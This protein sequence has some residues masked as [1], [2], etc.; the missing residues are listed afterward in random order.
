MKDL[1]SACARLVLAAAF[2][3]CMVWPDLSA[4]TTLGTFHY[5]YDVSWGGFRIGVLRLSL[6]PW[7]GHTDCYRYATKTYPNSIV[8]L[9]YG[10]PSEVSLFCLDH[11][12]IQ[13]KRFVSTLPGRPA[14][15]YTLEFNWKRGV[16]TNNKG[17]TRKIPADAVDGLAIQQA[18]RLWMLRHPGVR[19]GEV[20]RFT[21]VDDKHL[22]KYKLQFE[23]KRVLKTPAG[24]FTTLLV[25]RIDTPRKEARFWLAPARKDMPV[26]SMVRNGDRP[27]IT[28]VLARTQ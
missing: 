20:A 15:S 16:V 21:M 19:P 13:S 2:L 23:G 3:L 1:A 25:R 22:T 14:Q 4:A 10:S 9:L 11:G 17:V 24:R 7:R 6:G 8:K 27:S 12:Q 28:L 18:V 5:N 26:K